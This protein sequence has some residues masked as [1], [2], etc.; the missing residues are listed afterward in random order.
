MIS[1]QS[2]REERCGERELLLRRGERELFRRGE[3]EIF[4]RGEREVFLGDRARFGERDLERAPRFGSS[5]RRQGGERTYC[6]A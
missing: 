6:N 2:R 4:R 3:R 5:Q 1:H